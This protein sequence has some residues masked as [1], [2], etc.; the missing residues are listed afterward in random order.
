MNN[1]LVSVHMI[2]YNH[3]PYIAQAIEGV[4]RQETNFPIE[5]VIGEDC[6]TDRTREIVM[7]YQKRHPDIIRVITSDQNVGMHKNNK[8]TIKACR[9]KYLTFCEGDDY[10]HHTKKLQM[11]V[12]YLEAHPEVVL[13]AH[14]A[15]KV[16]LNN[17]IRTAFPPAQPAYLR[18]RDIIVKGGGFFATNSM[19]LKRSLLQELPDWFCTFP[20]GD[21][22]LINLAIQRGKVGFVNEIMSAYRK[23][24]PGSWTSRQNS[25][26]KKVTHLLDVDKAYGRLMRQEKKYTFWYYEKRLLVYW[27]IVNVCIRGM[28]KYVLKP[29]LRR[30][31]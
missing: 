5:L 29:F 24:V 1:P 26:K 9:G 12:D 2:T 27:K 30:R 25:T 28:A 15:H 8:R 21:V 10:W 22:P 7:E 3:E 14:R 4:L 13:V 23:N 31:V 17:N 19:M 6:S 11:Q 16:D 20:V 18:P